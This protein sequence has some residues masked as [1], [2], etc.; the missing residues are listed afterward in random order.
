MDK[1][2]I[3]RVGAIVAVAGATGFVA[4]M[5]EDRTS[6]AVQPERTA[7]AAPA[8]PLGPVQPQ[9]PVLAAVVPLA[10]TPALPF[11]EAK[12]PAAE[13]LPLMLAA[14]GPA[15]TDSPIVPAI[16]VPALPVAATEPANPAPLAETPA[17]TVCSED[18]AVL[19]QPG[20]MLDLGLLAPCR[21]D[22]RVLI[23]HG[24]LVVTARTSPAGTLVASVPAL[25][26]PAEVTI[27]FADGTSVSH[28][29]DVPDLDRFDRFAVQWM[30][31]D[32][33]ALHAFTA[34]VG[35]GEPGHIHA[36]A[37]GQPGDAGGFVTTLGD[38]AAER[39][40]MAQVFTWPA[41]QSALA[42]GTGLQIEAQVSLAN[43]GREI[44]GET[45][46]L[47]AGRL[48]VREL[49][50]AMPECEAAGE[51]VVLPNPVVAEKLAAN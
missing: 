18:L 27:A 5:G 33:F 9:A 24:G 23:R 15:V 37:P 3:L 16:T 42:N 20:A 7:V 51:Y 17:A 35:Y 44:L 31:D 21:P 22:Q 50:I 38:A 43:C 6:G 12:A 49:T 19:P 39:P 2:R 14:T 25:Q 4:Q 30:A 40:L 48:T 1:K 26:S 36:A 46:Q 13:A 47:H 11:P 34:G 41:G 8:A 45:L 29:L 32:A 10:S 28:S